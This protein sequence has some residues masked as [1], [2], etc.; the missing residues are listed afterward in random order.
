[1]AAAILLTLITLVPAAEAS[2]GDVNLRCLNDTME[3]LAELNS[4]YPKA[5]AVLMY[6]ATG[7]PGSGLLMGNLD[8]PGAYSECRSVQD[9]Q[10]DFKGEY[11]KVHVEQNGVRFVIGICVPDSC[12]SQ[13]VALLASMGLLNQG[14]APFLA[15]LPTI[16]FKNNGGVTVAHTVCSRGLFPA[17]TFAIV[18][19]CLSGLLITLPILGSI[20]TAYLYF[21]GSEAASQCQSIIPRKKPRPEKQVIQLAFSPEEDHSDV[22]LPTCL[23]RALRCFSIQENIRGMMG[24]S[25]RNQEYPALNGI[26]GLSL[27]WIISGHTNQ[28]ASFFNFDNFYEWRSRVLEKPVYFYSLSGP[29]Y[30]GVDSFFFLSGFLGVK[31]FLH[32]IKES[33]NEVSLS[34]MIRYIFKRFIRIQPLHLAAITLFIALIS[35]VEWGAIWELPKHQWDSCSHRWWANILLITNFVSDSCLAW[36]WYLS[37]DFQFHLT[38]PLL[39]FFYVKAN[40]VLVAIVTLLFIASTVTSTWLSFFFELPIRYPTPNNKSYYNYW[41]EYYFK[42]YCRYGPFLVGIVVAIVIGNR[43]LFTNKAQAT[44]GWISALLI[45]FLVISLAF[46][47]DD[48]PSSYSIITALYQGVH[49]TLWAAAIGIIVVLCHKGYGGYPNRLLSFGAWTIISRISYACYIVH[50]I[51]IILHCGLQER[52]LHYQDITMFYL[53][54]GHCVLTFP[55]GLLLTLLVEKPFQRL[56]SISFKKRL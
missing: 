6:D 12:T 9:P 1:M 15:P 31:T 56:S 16:I 22:K 25:D 44:A 49:R 42:P 23:G 48:A 30:L 7:K 2:T 32:M 19:L 52:L 18:C 4:E 53:F 14:S 24:T 17:N 45:M 29:I 54:I 51:I 10:V 3:Y 26:R 39:I 13:D 38:I 46:L 55:A 34:M 37:N 43:Q 5:Y 28:L 47:L 35:L 11:C 21:R 8:R 50:P 36:A 33:G 41:L 27:L 40:R 20:Y